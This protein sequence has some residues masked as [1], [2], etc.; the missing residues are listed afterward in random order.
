[1]YLNLGPA[2]A[3]RP[4]LPNLAIS[5]VIILRFYPD[6]SRDEAGLLKFFQAILF[7]REE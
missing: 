4:L 3:L 1:M 2:T 7:F 6:K 5:K